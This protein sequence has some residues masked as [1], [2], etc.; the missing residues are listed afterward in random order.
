MRNLPAPILSL[1]TAHLVDAHRARTVELRAGARAALL[2][3]RIRYAERIATDTRPRDGAGRYL[4]A[5]W[6]AEAETFTSAD[7]AWFRS[8]VGGSL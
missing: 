4:S 1:A 6:L 5:S 7:L 2:A 3:A 8:P